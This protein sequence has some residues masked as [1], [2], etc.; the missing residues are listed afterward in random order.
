MAANAAY[1]GLLTSGR[2]PSGDV[3]LGDLQRALA[4][5]GDDL[6][7]V[8]ALVTEQRLADGRL[9][10]E[11]HLRRVRLGRS[12]DRVLVRLARRVLDVH[13]RP[14]T[15][16]VGGQRR[17]VHD[18]GR[19]QLVLEGRDPRL[20]HRLLVL[21]VVVLGVLG[22]VPELARLLDA[23]RDLA[24][25]RR[26]EVVQL[27]LEVGEAL[28]GEDDVLWHG[29]QTCVR[30]ICESTTPRDAWG[31]ETR[32]GRTGRMSIDT[33]IGPIRGCGSAASARLAAVAPVPQ[34]DEAEGD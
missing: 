20:E 14:D 8:A 21:R 34:D 29:D 1:P 11:L 6:H 24:P 10:G 9:V 3:D 27:R 25:T 2:L 15:H 4:A 31:Q 17:G 12:D 30:V 18:R 19:S 28:R 23:I 26:R 7:V 13:D 32:T 33:R 16:L 5:R 22:D